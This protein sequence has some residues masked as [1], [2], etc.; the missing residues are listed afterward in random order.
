MRSWPRNCGRWTRCMRSSSMSWSVNHR[1]ARAG[2][3]AVL[4]GALLVDL[5]AHDLA[6]PDLHHDGARRLG[7]E[8]GVEL[9]PQGRRDR[10]VGVAAHAARTSRWGTGSWRPSAKRSSAG[11]AR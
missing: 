10:P 11:A 4:E 1:L 6:L 8:E 9:L 7:L 3:L 5:V 2:L